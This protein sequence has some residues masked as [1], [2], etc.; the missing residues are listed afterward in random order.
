MGV[1]RESVSGVLPLFL[2]KEH[3]LIAKLLQAPLYG[4]MTCLDP[5]GFTGS[6]ATTIPFLVLNQALKDY[7]SEKSEMRKLILDLVTETCIDLMT[8]NEKLR[9]QTIEFANNFVSNPAS[10]T[11]N[12]VPSI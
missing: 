11:Q 10:R 7:E 12:I 5:M 6:Q 3:K 4:F 2:F 1:G 9:K 8:F